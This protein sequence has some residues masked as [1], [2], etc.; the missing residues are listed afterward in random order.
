MACPRVARRLLRRCLAK[1]VRHRLQHI[2]DAR[3]ELEETRDRPR[4]TIGAASGGPFARCR[5]WRAWL[6]SSRSGAGLVSWLGG[7]RAAA[8]TNHPVARLDVEVGGR[9]GQRPPRFRCTRSS[10][11]SRSHPTASGSSC[12]HAAARG[13]HSSFSASSPG[14]SRERFPA[15]TAATRPFFSPDGRWIGFWRP[16]IA[17]SVRVSIGRRVSDRDR[18]DGRPVIALWGSNDEIVIRNRLPES[19]SCG[20]S[21][22]ADGTPKAIAVRDRLDGEWISLRAQIPGGNDLL[23]AS[24]RSGATWLDVLSPETGK[25]R[26][27]LRGGSNIH[28][29]LH[30]HAATSC[31]QTPTRC[32]RCR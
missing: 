31:T 11:L 19:G 28:G 16:R 27:L 17:S 7:R 23:V 6:S 22:Q 20:R 10:R 2:G 1:D 30:T 29:A 32:L 26:R 15:P 13:R 8:L 14:S 4:R 9:N 18:A 5:R 24:T 12:A 21:R 3:L 25:R